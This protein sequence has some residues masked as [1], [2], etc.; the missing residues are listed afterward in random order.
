MIDIDVA[1]Y[2]WATVPRKLAPHLMLA[3]GGIDRF[4]QCNHQRCLRF[5]AAQLKR[6]ALARGDGRIQF[7]LTRFRE[8]VK[9]VHHAFIFD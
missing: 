8:A 9:A 4:G 1:I 6:E 7:Y 3:R 2:L 5:S